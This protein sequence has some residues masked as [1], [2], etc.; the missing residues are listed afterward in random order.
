[1]VVQQGGTVAVVDA[2]SLPLSAGGAGQPIGVEE[3]D[4]F[5]VAGVLIHVVVQGEIH[6]RGPV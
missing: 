5:A 6:G 3:L 1:L 4:E 2:Q